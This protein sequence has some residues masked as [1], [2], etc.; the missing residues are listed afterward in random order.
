MTQL[1]CIDRKTGALLHAYELSALSSEKAESF[2]IHLMKCNYC[3]K[4]VASFSAQADLLRENQTV[5]DETA[6]TAE[7]DY[8]SSEK[9]GLINRLLSNLWPKSPI[10]F[11][12]A[13]SFLIIILLLIPAYQGIRI[14]D[15]AGIKPVETISL[16]PDRSAGVKEVVVGEADIVL[17]FVFPDA[18]VDKEYIIELSDIRGNILLREDS[19]TGFDEYQT[20]YLFMPSGKFKPGIYQ[21]TISDPETASNENTQV[22][23]FKINNSN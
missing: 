23:R 11:R 12:P 21:L 18:I 5:I 20:G 17:S 4:E 10:I 8:A 2:E 7:R 13:I 9:P 3:F 6:R 14:D 15:E 19:F 1:E 22:F 16:Y